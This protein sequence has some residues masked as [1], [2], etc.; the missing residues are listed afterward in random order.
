MLNFCG[1][2]ALGL[3]CENVAMLIG[4]PWMGM[5]LIFWVITNVSAAFYDIDTEPAFYRWGYACG[6]YITVR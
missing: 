6:R 2:A 4:Q 5:W 1:M 3:A